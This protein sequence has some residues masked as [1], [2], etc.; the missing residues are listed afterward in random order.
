MNILLT[1]DDGIHAEGIRKLAEALQEIGNLY[2]FAP[3]E[4]KSGCGHGLTL[5]A[6]ITVKETEFPGA[7]RAAAVGGTPTDCVKIGL[8]LLH[9]A[10]VQIDIVYSGVNQGGNLGTDTLYSGTVSAA[11]E[12]LLCGKPAVA[13]SVDAREP[14]HYET[15][16]RLAVKA[17]RLPPGTQGAGTA[18]NINAPDLPPDRVK[19]VRVTRLGLREYE[20]WFQEAPGGYRYSSRPLLRESLSEDC[21]VAA[22]AKGYATITPLHYDLTDLERIEEVKKWGLDNDC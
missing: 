19:G 11:I 8:K 12:G 16:C 3:S 18:L 7:V 2:V 13:V 21:D 14:K 9:E 17:G 6:P 20:E 5:T 4:Q 22:S 10:G 1:N 15:A